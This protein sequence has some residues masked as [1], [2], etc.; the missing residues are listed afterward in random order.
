MNA[1]D[2]W[3]CGVFGV[4]RMLM[5]GRYLGVDLGDKR[6]GLALGDASTRIATPLR[7]VHKPL[8]ERGGEALLDALAEAVR[9]DLGAGAVVLGLPLNMDGTEGSRAKAVREFG[10]RLAARTGVEVIYHDER[11]TTE[12]ANAA[13]ARTGL[14]RGQKKARRDALAAAV[15][16]SDFLESRFGHGTG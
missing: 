13:M 8:G 15:M 9:E 7:V 3:W 1:C 16:L 10:A 12:S 2:R 5:P 6:T 4:A 14:T 11:L